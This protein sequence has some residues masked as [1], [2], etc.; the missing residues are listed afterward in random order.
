MK[1]RTVRDK[2]EPW[3]SDD[4]IEAIYEKDKAWKKTKKTKDPNDIKAAKILR[5]A[6]KNMVRVAKADFVQDY[7][8]DEGTT[9]KKF[10]EKVQYVT[11]SGAHCPQINLINKLNGEPVPQIDTPEYINEFFTNIG[12]N[13]AEQFQNEWVDNLPS[14]EHCMLNDFVFTE[15]DVIEVIKDI[16]VHMSASIDDLSTRVL[17][18]AF[19][20]LVPQLTYMFNC[21]LRTSL[22]PDEWKRATVVPL[23]KSGDKSDVNNLRPVSLLPLPG[24]LLERLF[25]KRYLVFLR[26]II[27]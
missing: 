22:F 23:Q 16:N 26:Q 25:L 18:D 10:W 24:K 17:K 2:N 8:D 4:I 1:Y 5:N 6:V 15:R 21:S 3:L 19:E 14:V 7:L 12:P 27:C 11:N 13:L 20:Y 9:S